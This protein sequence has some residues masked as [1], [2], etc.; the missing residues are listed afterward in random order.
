M[1]RTPF[2]VLL[3]T[4]LVA[5]AS[6]SPASA[7]GFRSFNSI[8]TPTKLPDG[9]ARTTELRPVDH[10]LVRQGIQDIVTAWNTGRLGPLLSDDLPDKSSLLDTLRLDLPKDIRMRVLSIRSIETLDQWISDDK[11]PWQVSRVSAIVR[12]QLEF[13]SVNTGFQRLEGDNEFLLEVRERLQ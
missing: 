11:K 5:A 4:L 9:A 1:P 8:Q 6:A 13:T 2:A 10:Q 12:T 3:V 7:R